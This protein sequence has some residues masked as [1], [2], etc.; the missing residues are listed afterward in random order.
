MGTSSMYF[1][2]SVRLNEHNFESG[3]GGHSPPSVR[4]S[5]LSQSSD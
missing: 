2:I 3:I 5:D 4:I 1:S